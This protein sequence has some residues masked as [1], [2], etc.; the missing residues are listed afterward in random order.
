[1]ALLNEATIHNLHLYFATTPL[2]YV[3][4]QREAALKLHPY[5]DIVQG[6]NLYF[7]ATTGWDF[8]S[9]LGAPSLVDFYR[10]LV[11]LSKS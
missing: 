5:R 6:N 11:A 1:M 4:A 10:V 3:V 9:G 8:A 7:P 2:F